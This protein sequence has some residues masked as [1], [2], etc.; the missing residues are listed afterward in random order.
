MSNYQKLHSF[1]NRLHEAE[2]IVAKFSDR[3]PV[4]VEK[5]DTSDNRAPLINRSKYLV[6]TDFTIG[7]LVYI[8][9]KR[10]NM[11]PEQALFVYLNN[12]L[13]PTAALMSD[14]YQKYKHEDKFLYVSYATENTYGSLRL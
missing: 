4:I 6:P 7:Q 1:E 14:M 3:V 9:R 12:E 10:I 5:G 2:R 13:P 11:P 8:I